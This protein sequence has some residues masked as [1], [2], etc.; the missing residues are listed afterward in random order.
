M[1]VKSYFAISSAKNLSDFDFG[2]K[3]SVSSLDYSIIGF[4]NWCGRTQAH[5][6]YRLHDLP[7]NDFSSVK[8]KQII[9]KHWL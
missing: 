9:I 2:I 6:F 4:Q 7:A 8:I 5:I 1:F 3:H